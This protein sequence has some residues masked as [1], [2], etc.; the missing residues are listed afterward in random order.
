M[1]QPA[2]LLLFTAIC[3]AFGC[4]K[5]ITKYRELLDKR[6]IVYP[7]PVSNF[8]AFQGNLRIKLQWYPSPDPSIVKYLVYWN[9]NSDSL[10]LTADHNNPLDSVHTVIRGLGEYVQNFVLHTVDDKGNRSIGQSLS[11][12]RIFGPLY[13]SSLINRVPNANKPPVLVDVNTY[14]L[15]FAPADTILN[16]GTSLTYEGKDG[17]V[18]IVEMG[19]KADSAML[20]MAGAGTKVAVRSSY[21]PVHRAIDTFRV[22]YSDTLV[23]K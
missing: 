20:T 16:T 19:P 15:F 22:T 5:D 13:V 11:G 9:N 14:K 1:K 7:G 18:R 2:L 10:V 3:V 23:L 21:V 6:E 8:R 4:S 17:Q 12:V